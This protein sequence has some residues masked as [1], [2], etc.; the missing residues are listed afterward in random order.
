MRPMP[1]GEP[2]PAPT[3]SG[4]R[5]VPVDPLTP[6]ELAVRLADPEWLEAPVTDGSTPLVVVDLT[7]SGAV[8]LPPGLPPPA[9]GGAVPWRVLVGCADEGRPGVPEGL[10][11]VLLCTG[12]AP[13]PWTPVPDLD[14]ALASLAGTCSVAP[15]AAGVLAQVLR[16]NEHRPLAEGT[17]V[18]SLAYSTL[19]AGPEFA[20]WLSASP[21]RT[22]RPA[23]DPVLV[24]TDED[25]GTVTLTLNRPEVRNAYDADTRDRLVDVLRSLAAMP[26]P[27][28]VR[29]QGRGS[30]FCSG[31]DLSQFGTTPDPVRA[32]AVRTSRLP[33]LLLRSV[34]ATARVHGSCVGAGIELPA[35]CRFVEA[36]DGATF[37]LPEVPMGLIPG[38][39]GTAS[40]PARI[41]RHRT[42][43]MAL[44]AAEVPAETALRWG[45]VD[46]VGSWPGVG[47][48]VG[49][50]GPA[51]PQ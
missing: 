38:A 45:L 13:P 3:P 5:T 47:V 46:A 34:G 42:A 39:G 36:D 50:E 25:T 2:L 27:P 20:R 30:S 19:L 21:P 24:H 37:R 49:E 9:P 43:Y 8:R 10:F 12:P 28:P 18:E 35:F 15:G 17:L 23:T 7:G 40:I 31:G 1:G 33:G 51:H 4:E 26:D 6:P 11:D 48:G 41:G 22:H 29:L 16:L 32:H 44:S 14:R